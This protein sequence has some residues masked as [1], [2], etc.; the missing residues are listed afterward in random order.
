[1]SHDSEAAQRIV[2]EEQL[3]EFVAA[4]QR[5]GLFTDSTLEFME[6]GFP[7]AVVTVHPVTGDQSIQI[8]FW[9]EM[10]IV[11]LS[12]GG[13]SFDRGI[14]YEWRGDE[15]E[16]GFY[17][18]QSHVADALRGALRYGVFAIPRARRGWLARRAAT[19]DYA[20]PR[21]ERERA[22]LIAQLSDGGVEELITPRAWVAAD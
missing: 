6:P 10:L 14:F 3:R 5:E 17:N 9:A 7:G 18:Q 22:D 16:L 21:S 13:D 1:M 11:N 19:Y 15:T 4:R 2:A 12:G 8:A 20:F